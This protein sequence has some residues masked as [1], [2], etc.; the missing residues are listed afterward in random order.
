MEEVSI[1]AIPAVISPVT[2]REPD[3]TPSYMRHSSAALQ[4][5]QCLSAG[6]QCSCMQLPHPAQDCMGSCLHFPTST[7]LWPEPS[8]FSLQGGE[9][10]EKKNLLSRENPDMQARR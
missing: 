2:A 6:T 3:P 8:L 4:S 10:K 1:K 5:A 9:E 7:L